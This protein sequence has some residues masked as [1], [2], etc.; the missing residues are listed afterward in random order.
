MAHVGL[1]I[2]SRDFDIAVEDRVASLDKFKIGEREKKEVL[3]LLGTMKK[4]VIEK[5]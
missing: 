2:S 1:Q 4:D 5:P 3:T